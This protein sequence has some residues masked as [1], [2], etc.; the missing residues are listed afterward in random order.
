ME[1]GGTD[2]HDQSCFWFRFSFFDVFILLWQSNC[3][4]HQQQHHHHHHRPLYWVQ[5]GTPENE[6]VY[7][8][9]YYRLSE[10][11]GLQ[12]NEG[13]RWRLRLRIVD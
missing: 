5:F 8:N 1:P 6:S 9:H 13:W 4:E 12:A 11:S 7:R 2:K 10:T 3:N